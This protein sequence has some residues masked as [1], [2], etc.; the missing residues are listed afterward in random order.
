MSYNNPPIS[1]VSTSEWLDVDQYWSAFVEKHHYYH[2]HL[3][4]IVEDPESK[5]YDQKQE[6]DL[7]FKWN[8]FD[9]KHNDRYNNQLLY[10]RPSYEYYELYR[11]AL[12]EHMIFYLTKTGGDSRTFP[13]LLPHQWFCEIYNVRF[14]L[15]DVTTNKKS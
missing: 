1:E 4:S 13:E 5:E 10:Q 15:Y 12:I 3:A 8:V 2:D 14:N 6:A 9:G 7:I 11:G